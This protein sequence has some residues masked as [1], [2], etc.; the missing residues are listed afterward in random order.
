MKHE[1]RIRNY[2]RLKDFQTITHNSKFIIQTMGV[3]GI[4]KRFLAYAQSGVFS[5]A[6][7]IFE[8]D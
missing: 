5:I 2:A 4:D 7:N 8:N 6:P 3:P 1:S